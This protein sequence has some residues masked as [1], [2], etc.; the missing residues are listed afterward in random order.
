MWIAVASLYLNRQGWKDVKLN[1][2]AKVYCCLWNYNFR[3]DDE[4]TKSVERKRTFCGLVII[5]FINSSRPSSNFLGVL[6]AHL[7]RP[8]VEWWYG[9]DFT[10]VVPLSF[11]NVS[12][13]SLAKT[14]LLSE[15]ITSGMPWVGGISANSDFGKRGPIFAAKVVQG[16]TLA[17]CFATFGPARPSLVGTN[18]G[19]LKILPEWHYIYFY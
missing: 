15:T 3:N 13:L 10:C 16:T 2:A 4:A 8:L 7:S 14:V 5:K 17:G 6:V 18:F 19:G 1:W 11:M 12:N 9:A